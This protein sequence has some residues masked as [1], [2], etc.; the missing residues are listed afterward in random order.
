MIHVPGVNNAMGEVQGA[1]STQQYCLLCILHQPRIR[2]SRVAG[3][4]TSKMIGVEHEWGHR[5]KSTRKIR[6][7]GGS[8][9]RLSRTRGLKRGGLG[10]ALWLRQR[11]EGVWP[12][13]DESP[14]GRAI[15]QL[16]SLNSRSMIHPTLWTTK[17]K[18]HRLTTVLHSH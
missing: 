6:K 17:V 15:W 1:Q 8:G 11:T 12:I 10:A 9:R 5:P 14:V 16:T 13:K 2:E 4:Q 7:P 3:V 18:P